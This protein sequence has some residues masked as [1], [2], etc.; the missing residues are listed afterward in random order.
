MIAVLWNGMETPKG[1]PPFLKLGTR[2]KQFREKRRESLAE[3]S[4]AVEID[5]EV[6]ERIERGEERPTEDILTLLISYFSLR[7]QEAVE[8]WEWA[9]FARSD[10]RIE[11]L[12][13]LLPKSTVVLLTLDVRV[14]YSDSATVI[15]NQNGLVLNFM[16]ASTQDQ[17]VPVARIGMSY[18]HAAKIMEVLQSALLRK[19]YLP[20]Q[21]LLPPGDSVPS[22]D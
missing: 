1:Q 22:Q 20:A 12:Q 11:A 2:L 13:E 7:E 17:P 18:E 10:S 15:G 8:L 21:K 19:K 16:Q 4:G 14:L 5:S 3:V 6:L 9:G